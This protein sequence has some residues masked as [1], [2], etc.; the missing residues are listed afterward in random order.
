MTT[1]ELQT[2]S[3]A[4]ERMFRFWMDRLFNVA[5]TMDSNQWSIGDVLADGFKRFGNRSL[6]EA[7]RITLMS[8]QS[9]KLALDTVTAFPEGKR[10]AKLK[11]ITHARIRSIPDG[12][13]QMEF[14][15]LAQAEGWDDIKVELEINKNQ[16]RPNATK[17]DP[18]LY[19]LNNLFQFGRDFNRLEQ[20]FP[21]LP[22]GQQV[23]VKDE[24]R[25]LVQK[26]N[27]W[28]EGA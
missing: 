13:A 26:L 19:R 16:L 28:L 14:F 8:P 25:K 7:R 9:I 15:E 1:T 27:S 3:E 2:Q 17:V 20:S 21:E 10:N 22:E 12:E 6:I 5:A 24:V 18:S 11:F 4:E 23:A